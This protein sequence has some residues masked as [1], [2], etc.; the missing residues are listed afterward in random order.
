M[1]LLSSENLVS[2]LLALGICARILAFR[3]SPMSWIEPKCVTWSRVIAITWLTLEFVFSI[4]GGKFAKPGG[5]C[6]LTWIA[7]KCGL[8]KRDQ[9]A[10]CPLLKSYKKKAYHLSG[11]IFPTVNVQDALSQ[12]RGLTDVLGFEGGFVDAETA[13]K[14][15]G[16]DRER[17]DNLGEEKAEL[18]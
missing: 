8:L 5:A 15:F 13:G 4:F 14:F 7:W 16:K 18:D 3:V 10:S 12:T 2:M 1:F 6:I 9:I 11:R 17:S